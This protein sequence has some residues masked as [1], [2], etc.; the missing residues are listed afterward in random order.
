MKQSA[1]RFYLCLFVS[2]MQLDTMA[3]SN[4]GGSISDVRFVEGS[5]KATW[6]D[7]SVDAVWSAPTA[8]TIV[9]YVRVIRADEV[10][11]YEMFAFEETQQGLMVQVR[12]FSP[13]LIARED[14]ETP[15]R[16]KFLEAGNDFALF[17][18]EGQAMRVRYERRSPNDFAIVIGRQKDGKWAYED[19]WKFTRVK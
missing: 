7:R 11:L 10:V 1:L 16:Y 14:K 2:I 9:G 18:K 6:G 8:E 15:D 19:F 4:E 17:E 12:H 3:Q 13:G 5:W